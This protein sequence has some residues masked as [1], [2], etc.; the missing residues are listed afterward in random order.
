MDAF[1]S[2]LDIA[3]AIRAKEVSPLEVAD[4]YLARID[5]LERELNTFAHQDPERVRRAASDASDAVARADDTAELPPFH[6]V[7]MPIKNL[8]PVAGWPCTYGSRG[9]STGPQAR[10]DPLVERFVVAGF[11]LLGMTNTPELGTISYTESDAHGITRNPWDATRTPGGS[12]GGSAA[13]VAAGMAPIAHAND[14]GG[15]IRIPASCC[16]LVGHKPSRGRVPNEFI[17]LEGLVAEHV[18]ARTVADSA[19][20]LDVGAVIDPLVFFSAPQPP[21][22]YAE[23]VREAPPPLRVGYTTTPAIDVPVDPACVAAVEEACRA[24]QASG[25]DVFETRL[26]VPDTDVLMAAFMSVWN[27]GSA[28]SPIERPDQMEPLNAALVAAAHGVDS[29]TFAGAVRQTQQLARTVLANFERDFDVLVTPTMACLPPEVGSWRAGTDIDPVMGLINCT[30][31]A[32]FTAIW[33]VC[34]LPATSVPTHNDAASGL[35]VGVQV[36]APAWRDDLCLQVAAQLEDMLPWRDRR[37][38]IA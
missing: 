38:P 2:A 22:P 13:A 10:S 31:M 8:N 11:V 21:K 1:A 33:N 4:V 19:A 23:L 30:P 9:A 20:T 34:G 32:A 7:P 28:W 25:N 27:T 5:K 6:G 14:G 24:L 35:P 3:A 29:L 36:V 17:E 12:S 16:G 37:P 15:S 18:V 26:V